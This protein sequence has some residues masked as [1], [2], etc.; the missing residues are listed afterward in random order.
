M[1]AA[2]N[3][4]H[5]AAH[6]KVFDLRVRPRQMAQQVQLLIAALDQ[7]RN[8]ARHE[9]GSTMADEQAEIVP[10]D[11]CDQY[12]RT[13]FRKGRGQIDQRIVSSSSGPGLG[14]PM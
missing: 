7:E 2:E 6:A 3:G 9:P 8:M 12:L 4:Q 14:Q 11:M 1:R 10:L 5:L 13:R